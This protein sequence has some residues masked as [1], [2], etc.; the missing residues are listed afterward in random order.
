[1]IEEGEQAPPFE[2]PAVRDGAIETVDSGAVFGEQ[3]VILAFYPGDFNPAC[4]G[5]E[6]GLDELDLFTMQKDVSV[7]A[8][9][10]DSVYSHLAFAEEYTLHMP[11]LS[12]LD[13]SVATA[14]GVDVE[15]ESVGYLVNRAV[16]VVDHTQTVQYAWRSDSPR[17][18]PDVEA[19]RQAIEGV[20]DAETA[21]SRY[22]VG[23]AHYM[24]GRRAFT[25]AMKAYENHEWMMAQTDFDQAVDEF[26]ESGDEFDT[27][28]RFAENEETTIYFER[29]ER[30][31]EALWRAAD[32]LRESAS[33]FASG[34]G[35]R[36]ESLRSDAEAPLETARDLHDPVDPDEFPPEEDPLAEEDAAEENEH[37]VPDDGDEPDASLDADIDAELTSSSAGEANDDPGAV[38]GESE[39]RGRE[40]EDST[41]TADADSGTGGRQSESRTT[42]PHLDSETGGSYSEQGAGETRSEPEPGD[43]QT[44]RK[45]A[46]SPSKPVDG[47]HSESP[48][49]GEDPATSDPSSPEGSGTGDGKSAAAEE[50]VVDGATPSDH[51][52]DPAAIDDTPSGTGDDEVGETDRKR[53]ESSGGDGMQIDEEELEEIT[54]ELEEQTEQ[55]TQA[56]ESETDEED[57]DDEATGDPEEIDLVDPADEDDESSEDSDSSGGNH[58]VPDSL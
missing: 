3:L 27:A 15:D 14:Y 24:E 39:T 58:G 18:L 7:L 12:D 35:A 31:A 55:A 52:R 17:A 57:A 11:L 41:T 36:A 9:S 42:E 49:G 29:A 54:A 34:E 51:Q 47:S 22:R 53:D 4:D 33:A 25:S 8:L 23:H 6:T 56:Q 30:K 19:I 43:S 50:S 21:L 45:A 44:G 5:T 28:T 37:F 38:A 48:A 10:G 32:W 26:D 46:G 20:G 1:M 40:P 2:L 13:G 16:V